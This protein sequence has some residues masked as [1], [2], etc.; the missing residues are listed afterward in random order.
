[1]AAAAPE[2]TSQRVYA[3]FHASMMSRAQGDVRTAAARAQEAQALVNEKPAAQAL[4]AIADGFAALLSGNP[5]RACERLD[6]AV[7]TCDDPI[8]KAIALLLLGRAH[9]LRGD[10]VGALACDESVL[11]LTSSHGESVFRSMALWSIGIDSWRKGD[12]RYAAEM[13]KDGLQLAQQLNDVRM[14]ASCLEVLAWVA[15]EDGEPVRAVVMMSAA[16]T[17]GRTVGNWANVFPDLRVFH[18]ECVA[19][20]RDAITAETYETAWA[21]GSSMSVDDAVASALTE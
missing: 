10:M 9:E 12:H 5:D 15:A 8:P 7:D 1:L 14:A 17:V 21:Q 18:E 16:D 4:V 11:A 2:P 19:R 3:L 13:L 20:V 6:T